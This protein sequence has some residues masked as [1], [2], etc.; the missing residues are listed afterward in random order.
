MTADA[1]DA[2]EV[3]GHLS[4]SSFMRT[5]RL[6]RLHF[7]CDFYGPQQL[8]LY[9]GSFFRSQSSRFTF[10]GVWNMGLASP[11]QHSWVS[12]SLASTQ[13]KNPDPL[14]TSESTTSLAGCAL[15]T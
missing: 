3:I 14:G 11:T 2:A 13:H 15:K 4:I 5:G 12:T 8:N 7:T 9:D 10:T 6:L 1:S